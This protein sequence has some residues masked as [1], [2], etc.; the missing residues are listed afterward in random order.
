MSIDKI[1]D[2]LTG[3]H[4]KLYVIV[5][6]YVV[7]CLKKRENKTL[8]GILPNFSGNCMSAFANQKIT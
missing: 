2:A 4:M 5:S 1:N 7:K 6:D 8:V 3:G